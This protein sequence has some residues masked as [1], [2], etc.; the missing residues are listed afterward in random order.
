MIKANPKDAVIRRQI[1]A[2]EFGYVNIVLS[3]VH[4][5]RCCAVQLP[6]VDRFFERGLRDLF[7][8]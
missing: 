2:V 5:V 1:E 8:R 3:S 6:A 4:I 7:A